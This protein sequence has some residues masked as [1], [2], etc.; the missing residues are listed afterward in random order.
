MQTELLLAI[1]TVAK[2]KKYFIGK[3][4][5]ELGTIRKRFNIIKA[6][7]RKENVSVLTKKEKEI[8]LLVSENLPSQE[9]ANRLKVSIRTVESH[10][11]NIIQKLQL[12]SLP[13][14]IGY[15]RDY[16]RQQNSNQI[17]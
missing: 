14:L 11:L 3:T 6:K 9:I 12:K 15:A 5:E 8:L 16:A 10:R 2:G 17:L 4:D 1:K 13:G 7:E